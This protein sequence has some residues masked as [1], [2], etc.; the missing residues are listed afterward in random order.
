ML[1]PTLGR[2]MTAT[3][4]PVISGPSAG[5]AVEALERRLEQVKSRL[6]RERPQSDAARRAPID[7]SR[8]RRCRWSNPS[9]LL[10]ASSTGLPLRRANRATN[11]SCGVTPARPSTTTIRSVGFGDGAFGLGDHQT[12]IDPGD[13]DET[14]RIDDDA[15]DLGAPRKIHTVDRG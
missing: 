11:S 15:R 5:S 4:M 8:R 6:D 2:P 13:F 3:L 7:G 9:V 14:T 10:T 12:S 1:L